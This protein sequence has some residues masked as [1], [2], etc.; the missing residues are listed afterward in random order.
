[1]ALIESEA[2][3]G[4]LAKHLG[5]ERAPMSAWPFTNTVC[6]Q[7]PGIQRVTHAAWSFTNMTYA[8]TDFAHTHGSSGRRFDAGHRQKQTA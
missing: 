5:H 8:R 2:L 6:C 7:I 1:M 4:H 3:Q